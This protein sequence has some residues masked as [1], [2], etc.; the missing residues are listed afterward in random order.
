M[1][2]AGQIR[3]VTNSLGG[4]G[5]GGSGGAAYGGSATLNVSGS[6]TAANDLYMGAS[7]T[8][9]NGVTSGG[10]AYGGSADLFVNGGTAS[11]L[12]GALL[13]ANAIGGNASNGTGG[14]GGGGFVNVQSYLGG[15]LSGGFLNAIT[16]GTGGDGTIAGGGY[17]GGIDISSDSSG[18]GLPTSLSFTSLNLTANGTQG[19][20]GSDGT[21]YGQ[22]GFIDLR[23]S[24]GSLS[25]GSLV[26]VA[27]GSTLGGDITFE[28]FVGPDNQAGG[29][30]FGTLN[31]T[32]NGGDSGGLIFVDADFG[33]TVDLGNAVLDASGAFDGS[34]YLFTGNCNCEVQTGLIKPLAQTTNGG[35]IANN[36]TMTTSGIIYV[37][38]TGGEGITVAGNLQGTA[39]AYI[40]LNDDGTGGSIQGNSIAL[41]GISILGNSDLAANTMAFSSAADTSLTG[42]LTAS[43]TVS[44]TAGG[45][46]SVS[47]VDATNSAT[48]SAGGLADFSGIVSAPT[49]TVTSGDINVAQGATL[50]VFGLTNL[51]TLN[52]VSNGLPI[53]IGDTSRFTPPAFGQYNLGNEGG[54][55][56]A[57]SL[58]INAIGSGNNPAPDIRVLDANPEGSA[59][60][61]GGASS[62]ILN[63]GGSVF[64]DGN[65]DFRN[66]VAGDSLTI[67]AGNNIEV[68]TD[69]GRIALLDIND[70]LAG[71]LTLN[72]DNIWIA[73]QSILTQLEANPNFAGRDAALA[74]NS[75]TSRFHRLRRRRRGRDRRIEHVVRPKQ[76]HQRQH[77]R[78][79]RRRRRF[80]DHQHG[81]HAR[82]GHR[83]RARGEFR[84]K[85]AAWH[86]L[87]QRNRPLGCVRCRFDHQR[88]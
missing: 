26:A 73:Q 79:H 4:T 28:S 75:G 54:D 16:S 23:G 43:D 55:I 22:G 31:A 77:G 38:L 14:Y 12:G 62:I 66:V 53:L 20:G 48:F 39:G 10:Y 40:S 25:A 9:G 86:R 87:C 57:T 36:L 33:T 5:S 71:T 51:L 21:T 74:V 64:V 88:L 18:S 61:G 8:G 72:A 81:Q 2:D 27:N 42:N 58:V 47:N 3:V 29:L 65:L 67:N 34:I 60:V 82:H 6:L 80:L 83:L 46:L 70:Q 45:N 85:H 52:A 11:F 49:I 30:Q 84:R 68:N 37:A 76:R 78:D 44:L 50:G 59:S 56:E 32:A 19:V 35:V 17:G 7:A 24:G 15:N 13:Q 69:T 1:L 41:S 63:T